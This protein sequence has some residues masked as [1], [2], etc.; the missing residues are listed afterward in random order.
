[1]GIIIYLPAFPVVVNKHLD[2]SSAIAAAN[3]YL[4]YSDV[5]L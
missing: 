2:I 4:I 3:A 5:H 1:M